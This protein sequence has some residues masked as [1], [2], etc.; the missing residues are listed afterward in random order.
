MGDSLANLPQFIKLREY[1]IGACGRANM[2]TTGFPDELKVKNDDR[3]NGRLPMTSAV[4]ERLVLASCLDD[5]TPINMLST[6]HLIEP[7]FNR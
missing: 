1:G 4:I 6:I 7:E 3:R 5:Y 2:R